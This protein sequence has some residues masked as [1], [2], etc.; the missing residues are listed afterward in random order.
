MNVNTEV[1]NIDLCKRIEDKVANEIENNTIVSCT[2]RIKFKVTLD[3]ITS[4]NE[5]LATQQESDKSTLRKLLR[6]ERLHKMMKAGSISENNSLWF[7]LEHFAVDR[8]Q[9]IETLGALIER[10]DRLK[11]TKTETYGEKYLCNY[12]EGD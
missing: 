5:K 9:K 3:G 1:K 6:H 7:Y 10:T 4:Y 12:F 11:G 8:A 2:A